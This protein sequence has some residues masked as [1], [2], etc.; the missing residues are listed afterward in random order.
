M[1]ADSNFD[2]FVDTGSYEQNNT[3]NAA[4]AIGIQD[5]I[6]SYLHKNDIDYYKVNLG[7][8]APENKPV[9]LVNFAYTDT[10]NKNTNHNGDNK[11]QPGE[12]AY[13]DIMVKNNVNATVNITSTVLSTASPYVT[14]DKGAG[15]IGNLN[16]GYYQTL[17]LKAYSSSYSSG[18][19]SLSSD[20]YLLYSSSY[21]SSAFK[22]TIS[23]SCPVGTL[24]PFTVTF[25]DSW[26]NTWT[27]NLTITVE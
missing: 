18:G 12:S 24:L 13:L 9:Q 8:T 26:G 15:T 21:Y 5:K 11:I 22:F 25:T 20:S 6:M 3:E 2:S 19:T 1:S 23:D 10:N 4:A 16:A 14:L 17:T 7:N 27:D